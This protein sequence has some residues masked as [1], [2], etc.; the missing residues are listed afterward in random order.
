MT[1]PPTPPAT[2]TLRNDIAELPQLVAFIDRFF[3][4]LPP[5][6]KTLNAFQLALEEVVLN[7]INHGYRDGAPH[8]FRVALAASGRR[9]T[10]TVDDDAP[11]FDP[12][13]QPSVDL[14][15]PLAGRPI[16]GLG[17]HLVKK[18]MDRVAYTRDR[19]RNLLTLTRDLR[20]DPA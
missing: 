11:A 12:L 8:T 9:V 18:M 10:A 14:D 1:A 19:G 15:A 2:L 7:V 16:G 20:A 3:A 6:P 5:D 17:I 4:R 13:A